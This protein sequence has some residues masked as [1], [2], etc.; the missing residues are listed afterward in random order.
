MIK[1]LAIEIDGII[2]PEKEC[3]LGYGGFFGDNHFFFFE[4]EKENE[5]FFKGNN[6]VTIEQLNSQQF[7]ELQLTDWYFVRKVELGIDVPNDVI[8]ERLA[9]RKKYDDLK[10]TL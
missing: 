9:I 6:K 2:K 10:T 3:D 5:D 4:S 8:L 7:E 1:T